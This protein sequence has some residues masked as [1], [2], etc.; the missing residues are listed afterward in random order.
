MILLVACGQDTNDISLNDDEKKQ[1]ANSELISRTNSVHIQNRY[2]SNTEEKT[3]RGHHHGQIK[4]FDREALEV[5]QNYAKELGFN[6][7]F[8]L[9]KEGII[10]DIPPNYGN[11]HPEEMVQKI[12]ELYGMEKRPDI[13]EVI[14]GQNTF[15][16]YTKF[17]IQ[18]EIQA[19]INELG[20]ERSYAYKLY[21]I[22]EM[23]V[24]TYRSPEDDEYQV[25]MEELFKY[26]EEKL[27]RPITV[28]VTYDYWVYKYYSVKW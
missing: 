25:K 22:N 21:G 15:L 24:D 17:T 12:M 26:I 1:E 11:W 8:T 3:N 23:Y 2:V 27:K 16:I 5:I 18:Q 14:A 9:V 10:M 28:E 13:S 4:Q 6:A 20:L 19:K 7:I